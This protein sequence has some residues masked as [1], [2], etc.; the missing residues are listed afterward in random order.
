MLYVA[1]IGIVSYALWLFVLKVCSRSLLMLLPA[2]CQR[3]GGRGGVT[4]LIKVLR[5]DDTT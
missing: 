4:K 3:G 2:I 5:P 1:I